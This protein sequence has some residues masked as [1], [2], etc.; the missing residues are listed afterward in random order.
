MF[1]SLLG[2]EVFVLCSFRS[3]LLL[4]KEMGVGYKVNK[5]NRYLLINM[6]PICETGDGKLNGR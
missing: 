1:N 6:K 4:T 5:V 2:V 3:F